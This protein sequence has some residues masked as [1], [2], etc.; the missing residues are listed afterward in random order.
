MPD[1]G[2]S[3]EASSLVFVDEEWVSN[4]CGFFKAALSRV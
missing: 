4:A 3:V 2:A 1:Y